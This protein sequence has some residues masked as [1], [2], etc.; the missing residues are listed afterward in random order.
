MTPSTN[1]TLENLV[2]TLSDQ[3]MTLPQDIVCATISS[4][5]H[6]NARLRIT[7]FLRD[8]YQQMVTYG[9]SSSGAR[10]HILYRSENGELGVAKYLV[11]ALF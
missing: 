5:Y 11:F 4:H 2:N 9:Y 3:Q 7:D 8:S 6:E 1:N 10:A